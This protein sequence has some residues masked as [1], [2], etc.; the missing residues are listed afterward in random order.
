MVSN[1]INKIDKNIFVSF[2]VKYVNIL[3]YFSFTPKVFYL[4]FILIFI[5]EK[6]TYYLYITGIY[7]IVEILI[8]VLKRV[9]KRKRPVEI[10][11]SLLQKLTGYYP[12]KYSFPSAHSFTV[13]LLLPFVYSCWGMYWGL[14]WTIYSLLVVCSRVALKHHFLSDVIA[15]IFISSVFGLIII[16]II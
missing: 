9:I 4:L 8:Y 14:L 12:D 1:I 10:K 7:F 3:K 11:S 5:I 15:S 13:F 16:K 2:L 6:R